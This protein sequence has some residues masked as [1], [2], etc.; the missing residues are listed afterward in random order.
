M[1]EAGRFS[2]PS[3]RGGMS[4]KMERRSTMIIGTV[5]SETRGAKPVNQQLDPGFTQKRAIVG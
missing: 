2:P 3:L 5:T 1:P 4:I